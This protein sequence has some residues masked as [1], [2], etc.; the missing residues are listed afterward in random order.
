MP[1]AALELLTADEAA[2]ALGCQR[3][4]VVEKLCAGELP[5]VKYGREWRL[6]VNALRQR[7]AEEAMKNLERRSAA[8][9]RPQAV[10][11]GTHGA[12]KRRSAPP[13]LPTLD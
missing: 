3:S 4:T 10:A 11:M 8:Q 12:G 13:V 7:L 5:G 2:A 9:P 1:A 6:P